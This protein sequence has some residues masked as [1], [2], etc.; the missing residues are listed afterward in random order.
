MSVYLDSGYTFSDFLGQRTRAAE[1]L[2]YA[3]VWATMETAGWAAGSWAGVSPTQQGAGEGTGV[4]TQSCVLM[5]G[6]SRG[7]TAPAG[8]RERAA[9]SRG[10]QEQQAGRESRT[11]GRQEQR[12]ARL[13]SFLCTN[14]FVAVL[15]LVPIM[16]RYR[17]KDELGNSCALPP[18]TQ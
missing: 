16:Y 1:V 11:A 15:V 18:T 5:V 4:K 17:N 3:D 13:P 7:W 12:A 8:G 6:S 2:T 10:Q 9:G 14:T